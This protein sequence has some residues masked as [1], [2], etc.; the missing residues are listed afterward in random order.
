MIGDETL[1]TTKV[2]GQVY[3]IYAKAVGWGVSVSILLLQIVTQVFSIGTN[4]WLAAWSDDPDSGIPEVRNVYLGVY[5]GL[6]G[7][8]AVTV[9]ISSLLVTIGGLF[10]SSK[11]HSKM[12]NRSS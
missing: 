7:A 5:G 11:L 4:F 2:K 12:L 1:E 8:S 10:A 6:G 9:G 3:L